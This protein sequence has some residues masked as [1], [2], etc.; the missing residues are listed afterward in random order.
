MPGDRWRAIKSQACESRTLAA[1]SAEAERLFWRILARTDSWGRMRGEVE[2]IRGNC[3]ALLAD[4]ANAAEWLQELEDVG[5]IERYPDADR[6][7]LSVV[8]FDAHQPGALIRR[9]GESVYPSRNGSNSGTSTGALPERSWL[10]ESKRRE[11]DQTTSVP[12]S[13][14][15]RIDELDP[16]QEVYDHW[17]EAR[18]KTHARYDRISDARRKKIASRLREFTAAS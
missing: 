1:L 15:L 18:R 17:R 9:R 5:L 4:T 13:E 2:L 16:V 11:E 7:I 8:N 14:K 3:L 12:E 6:V 10:E